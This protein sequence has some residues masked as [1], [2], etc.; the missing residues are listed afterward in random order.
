MNKEG[1]RNKAISPDLQPQP[2]YNN[3]RNGQMK[4]GQIGSQNT[5]KLTE[6]QGAHSSLFCRMGRGKSNWEMRVRRTITYRV[7]FHYCCQLPFF[8]KF[9]VVE[10]AWFRCFVTIPLLKGQLSL[11]SLLPTTGTLSKFRLTDID[12]AGRL[13]SCALMGVHVKDLHHLVLTLYVMVHQTSSTTWRSP[14]FIRFYLAPRSGWKVIY[15]IVCVLRSNLDC[16]IIE[17]LYCNVL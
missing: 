15:Y 9:S 17:M 5:T 10:W 7:I 14:T 8:C 4:W 1:C 3:Q 12:N 16:S 11:C 6:T 13:P 2:F